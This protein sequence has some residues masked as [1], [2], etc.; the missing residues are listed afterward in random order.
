MDLL[1]SSFFVFTDAVL[2]YHLKKMMGS[3]VNKSHK[4][5]QKHLKKKSFVFFNN[6]KA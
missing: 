5:I 2:A 6:F 4:I 1:F 3:A